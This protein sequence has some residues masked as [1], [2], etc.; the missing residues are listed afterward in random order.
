MQT[1]QTG[2]QPY[3]DISPYK[4]S[5]CSLY[6]HF[7][8]QEWQSQD[9]GDEQHHQDVDN[10]TGG[11]LL[12]DEQFLAGNFENEKK[13]SQEAEAAGGGGPAWQYGL[14]Y[15]D[16]A[17]RRWIC[18]DQDEARPIKPSPPEAETLE[19]DL[20]SDQEDENRLAKVTV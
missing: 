12:S 17:S 3:S 1:S 14:P 2:G 4:V 16:T 15:F 11:Q 8:E 19:S 10:D 20:G 7:S 13:H 6:V 5:E 18:P 9:N